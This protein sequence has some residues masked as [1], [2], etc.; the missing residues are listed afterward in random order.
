MWPSVNL[1]IYDHI[2]IKNCQLYA[3][4]KLVSKELYNTLL[5]SMYEKP[6]SQ[7]YF[8]KLLEA[9]NLNGKGI[10]ILPRRDFV[11]TNL[12]M[13]QIKSLN[14]ILFLNKLL[15]KFKK[16]W[17]RLCSLCNFENKTLMHIFF[18]CNI[19]KQLFNEWTSIF[20]FSESLFSWNHFTE[21][22]LWIL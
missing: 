4:G 5:C 12:R 19:K 20:C 2:L 1:S 10:H 11:D 7:S 9:K 21:C 14:N 16:N 17:S 18:T 15:F 13:F 22:P 8:E 6:T 3:L